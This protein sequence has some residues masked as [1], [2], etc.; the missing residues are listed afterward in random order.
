MKII[1][2][3]SQVLGL[4][5]M[6]ILSA[7]PVHAEDIEVYLVAGD[8]SG[9]ANVLILI[10][11]A[12]ST[13]TQFKGVSAAPGGSKTFDEIEYAMKVVLDNVAGGARMGIISQNSGGTD[14]GRVDYP[15]SEIVESVDPVVTGFIS[16]TASE[17]GQSY[18]GASAKWSVIDA[19]DDTIT[20]PHAI[21]GTGNEGRLGLI[22]P[23]MAVPRYAKIS[24]AILEMGTT[25]SGT[26]TNIKLWMG[27]EQV[28]DPVV[29]SDTVNER[30]NDRAWSPKTVTA[31]AD[32]RMSGNVFQADV[33]NVIQG[34]V[35]E[36]T[37]CG[38]SDLSLVI[39]E[40]S[41]NA[42][43]T[44]ELT[45]VRTATP[46]VVNG[47]TVVTKLTV[48][49]DPA[50]AGQVPSATDRSCMGGVIF[51]PASDTD[52]A[53]ELSTGGYRSTDKM[54][55]YNKTSNPP[56]SKGEYIGGVRFA[57]IPFDSVANG[58]EIEAA[59]LSVTVDSVSGGQLTVK[60][61]LGD[62]QTFDSDG[63]L[64]S[65]PAGTKSTTAAVVAGARAKIDVTDLVI[66]ALSDASWAVGNSTGFQFSKGGS[67]QVTVHDSNAG[68]GN[69]A[70]LELKLRAK[71]PG[72]F[73]STFSRR[74]E[75]RAVIAQMSAAGGGGNAKPHNTYSEAARYML[76]RGPNFD[77][78][79]GVVEAF[80]SS[81][82]TQYES[83]N[84][85]FFAN[86]ECGGNHIILV[87]HSE[88]AQEKPEAAVQSI[89]G[90]ACDSSANITV[91]GVDTAVGS[92]W[93]CDGSLAAYLA[94]ASQNKISVPV[95]THTI[96]FA[97]QKAE[98]Y[99]N[100]QYLAQQG[101]G[102]YFNSEDANELA[103][104]LLSILDSITISNASLAAPGVA[105]NQLN[106]FRHLDQLFYGVFAPAVTT[107]WEGNLK[108]YR[109]APGPA[110]VDEQG[111]P[112]VDPD[113]GFFKDDSDSWWG[114]EVDGPTVAKGG[115]RAELAA[116]KLFVAETVPSTGSATANSKP[117]G[118]TTVAYTNA[119]DLA[120]I[121][122]TRFGF[123]A[124]EVDDFQDAFVNIMLNGWGDPLHSEPRLANFGFSGAS[125][126]A[127]AANPDLQ[128]NLVFVATNDGMIHAIDPIDG[129]E[130]WAFAPSG[131]AKKLKSRFAND[132]MVDQ[133]RTTYGLD[134]GMT[135]WRRGDGSTGVEHVLLYS[136]QRRGGNNYY[137]LDVTNAYNGGAPGLMWV[138]EGGTPGFKKLGQTWSSPI[139]AQVKVNGVATPVLIFNG[140]FDPITHDVEGAVNTSGDTVGNSIY[141]VNA[142]SGGLIWSAND[143]GSDGAAIKN[144]DMKWSMPASPAVVDLDFDGFV[145]NIYS[146][147]L[148]GQIFRVDINNTNT[149]AADLAY[150]V[151]TFAQLGITESNTDSDSVT[152]NRQFYAQPVVGS[153]DR[154]NG[155]I[156][157]VGIGSGNRVYPTN[158]DTEDR[159]FLIDDEEVLSAKQAVIPSPQPVITSAELF[160][161]TD[162][163]DA[164]SYPSTA[165][166]W[167]IDLVDNGEKTVSSGAIVDGKLI[168]TSYLPDTAT[169]NCT[170][171]I[172]LSRLY[173]FSVADGAAPDDAVR[174]QNIQLPG[175]SPNVNVT[176]NVNEQG[177][178]DLTVITG[179]SVTYGGE[180]DAGRLSRTRWYEVDHAADAQAVID[181]AKSQAVQ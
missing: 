134:G 135:F 171:V 180:A 93:A 120:T 49:W 69:A 50:D 53:S 159:I 68:A 78:G 163:A 41:V 118:D 64:A 174:S 80:T 97:P 27:H 75:I 67:S 79:L 74:D 155:Y 131:E 52:D 51:S 46:V 42:G 4:A 59:T 157:Q 70:A 107:R 66:E 25:D 141:I 153:Y 2:K 176:V 20:L 146:V 150:R 123:T 117:S 5:L 24:K 36:S 177:T 28:S 143:D 38:R 19:A 84:S 87:N 125:L 100:M 96:A 83:P 144:S 63:V 106:R 90:S 95:I 65:T 162:E 88:S 12:G 164:S 31:N 133:K 158:M 33:T 145:D 116:R 161:V 58:T 179:T 48:Y 39:F 18:D 22:F 77:Q 151:K 34:A 30:V 23:T 149:S 102:L 35:N 43:S 76:G 175:L 147:D 94:D 71:T 129:S 108:R 99:T 172:G 152:N 169:T 89:T 165:K 86:G 11:N 40:S 111:I 156:L 119:S 173:T 7:P 178:S 154:G 26:N 124:A 115:A 14:G 109:L 81:T 9:G 137:G 92:Q 140:G 13:H 113:S 132:K 101:K 60:A 17:A 98:T 54:V 72:E 181:E 142:W 136:G 8:D 61:L 57:D 21:T 148:A 127:A 29:F 130:K 1:Q 168:M 91:N 126:E 32:A 73:A 105:V 160:D 82:R 47:E 121:D 167:Y 55:M 85:K 122:E 170:K 139:L 16:G 3:V 166:G 6:L 45:T 62:V 15:V 128:K 112:A 56:K 114:S 138:I 44:P 104:A 103:A 37:W 110:I 10:D